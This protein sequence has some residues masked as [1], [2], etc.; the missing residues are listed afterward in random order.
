M[1]AN[2]I[3]QT[4]IHCS[5]RKSVFSA[6]FSLKDAVAKVIAK[7][8]F[9]HGRCA[10]VLFLAVMARMPCLA[11]S[12]A[13][14]RTV[15]A[16]EGSRF[17]INGR[18]T[19]LY[20]ISYYGALGASQQSIQLDLDDMQRH[21]FNWIRVWATW[22]AFD[23]DVSAVDAHGRPRQPY[24]D[25]LKSL[26]HDCD[27]RGLI[28]DLTLTRGEAVSSPHLVG[29]E[30]HE[31]AV[32]VL[33]SQFKELRNWYV[34][35]ANEHNIRGS[36]KML[37]AVPFEELRRLR[38]AAKAVDPA[39]LVTASHVGDARTEDLRRYAI[40]VALDFICP[41]RDRS[42]LSVR[43]T[44]VRT[45]EL[46]AVMKSIDRV[47]PIHYREP[48]RRDFNPKWQPAPSDFL[49][50][51]QGAI[52]GGAAGW[53]FHNGVAY[54]AQ[55]GWDGRPRRSFD[56]REQRLFEQ[57]DSLEMLTIRQL[58]HAVTTWDG[59]AQRHPADR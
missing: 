46:L 3:K 22:S 2:V 35:L 17:T 33:C 8:D 14:P 36:G 11:Q 49:T 19:F 21:G 37:A 38:N 12:T 57:L 32:R 1:R 23:H 55:G 42:E 40:D 26:I 30:A 51:L 15:L 53:C 10:L 31:Q 59:K 50:D 28:V 24:F 58:T 29:V 6:G 27:R 25:L 4:R 18:Q 43:Q 39:R 56:M 5:L 7:S 47:L 48:M 44:H 13:A 9:T 41:H 20:G 34:D 16:V 54:S 52:G 45:L